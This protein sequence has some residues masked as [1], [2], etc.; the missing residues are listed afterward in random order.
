MVTVGVRPLVIG[1]L[2]AAAVVV[3]G[4]LLRRRRLDQR[5]PGTT[6]RVLTPPPTTSV[7]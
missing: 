1:G 4:I 2:V 5:V 6:V 3:S 7:G